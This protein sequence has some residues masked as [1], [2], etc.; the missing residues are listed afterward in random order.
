MAIDVKIS[1]ACLFTSWSPGQHKLII[2]SRQ[3]SSS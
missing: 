3:F 2:R 1:A